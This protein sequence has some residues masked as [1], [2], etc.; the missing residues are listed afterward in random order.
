MN[1]LSWWGLNIYKQE[2]DWADW[3][4]SKVGFIYVSLK[5]LMCFWRKIQS[6]HLSLTLP[7]AT[8]WDW[9]KFRDSEWRNSQVS[10]LLVLGMPLDDSLVLW[11]GMTLD[12]SLVLWLGILDDSLLLWLGMGMV[13][14]EMP[15]LCNLLFTNLMTT[16]QTDNSLHGVVLDEVSP[17]A[18][19][20]RYK[21]V[22]TG[23]TVQMTLE[24]MTPN[25]NKKGFTSLLSLLSPS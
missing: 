10:L 13:L 8:D 20:V 17:G 3:S 18:A 2:P 16:A 24:L 14:E 25:K 11:L 12:D 6:H 23:V 9:E 1:N 5:W 15:G 19:R 22:L 4:G 7:C 21:P